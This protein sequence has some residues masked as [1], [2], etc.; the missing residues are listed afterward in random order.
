MA[1]TPIIEDLGH[2]LGH[3]LAESSQQVYKRAWALYR[4][5][6]TQQN[7]QFQ[8]VASLPIHHTYVAAFISYMRI[9]G[10]AP[11]SVISYISALGYVHRLSGNTD[12]T[13]HN[14]IQKLLSAATKINPV[15]DPR[16]PITMTI[17]HRLVQAVDTTISIPYHRILIKAMYVVAFF[18]LMRIGEIT[19]SKFGEIAL[20]L[21]Q[22]KLTT[23]QVILTITHF[24]HN[25]G[26]RP[27]QIYLKEQQQYQICPVKVMHNYLKVRGAVQG[28]L[29]CFQDGN[30]ISRNFFTTR[31][32]NALRFI[33]LDANLYK[34]HSFRIGSASYYASLGYS[35]TQIK[36]MGRWNSNAFLRYIRSQ[37][38]HNYA[39]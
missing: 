7:I 21:H 33:G 27:V 28:P 24:K 38:M 10:L 13:H 25:K 2:L 35:D 1:V 32:T 37:K 31:L 39:N 8:G 29:F 5:F 36:I 4:Q 30:S 12:P 15:T 19:I 14:L 11:T 17:L 22:V 20:M 34:S 18:G 26:S 6:A 23:H 16:L 3:I 9:R